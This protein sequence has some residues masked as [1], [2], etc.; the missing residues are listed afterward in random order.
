[1][2]TCPKIEKRVQVRERNTSSARRTNCSDSLVQAGDIFGNKS[3]QFGIWKAL[4]LIKNE[5][6]Q[7]RESV[8]RFQVL[9]VGV[10]AFS[11]SAF[12]RGYTASTFNFN[13][14]PQAL[15]DFD[16][17]FLC[18]ARC[19]GRDMRTKVNVSKFVTGSSAIRGALPCN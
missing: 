10:S 9:Q 11:W 8:A 15:G 18:Q 4:N 6:A 17:R 13:V 3:R 7:V 12:D 1:M 19:N 5:S 2:G 14:F 16:R